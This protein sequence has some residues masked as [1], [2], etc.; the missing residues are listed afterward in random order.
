MGLVT[1][2]AFRAAVMPMIG[3][4]WQ[5]LLF[6]VSRRCPVWSG[7]APAAWQVFLDL[8]DGLRLLQAGVQPQILSLQLG[9]PLAARGAGGR[10]AQEVS[11]GHAC[12]KSFLMIARSLYVLDVPLFTMGQRTDSAVTIRQRAPNSG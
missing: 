6:R 12:T 1:P 7:E 3:A 10:R 8:D 2:K 4:S 5:A 9:H 11:S